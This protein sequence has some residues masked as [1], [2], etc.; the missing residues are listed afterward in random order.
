[1]P[2][3]DPESNVE[4]SQ[5]DQVGAAAIFES[6]NVKNSQY[7]LMTWQV[8]RAHPPTVVGSIYS[9]RHGHQQQP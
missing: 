2:A 1:V 8:V 6:E 7:L 3:D 9:H 5:L 4:Q